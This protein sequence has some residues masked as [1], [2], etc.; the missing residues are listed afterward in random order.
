MRPARISIRRFVAVALAVSAFAVVKAQNEPDPEVRRLYHDPKAREL[1]E[2]AR[3]A[4]TGGPGG[5]ARL[6]SLRLKGQSQ[7]S[8]A[9]GTPF[10]GSVEVRILLPD[11][12]LRIDTGSFGRRLT[13]YAGTAPLNLIESADKHVVAEPKDPASVESARFDLARFMLNMAWVSNEVQVKLYTRETPVDI[14]G[15]EYSPGVDAVSDMRFAARVTFDP[16]SRMPDRVIYRNGSTVMITSVLDRKS[17]SGYKIASHL[18]TRAG[19]RTVD[20]LTFDE[21]VVN[22]S[23]AKTD[24][25]K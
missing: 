6:R 1:F 24:F 11:R 25:A 12:Y 23:L 15:A 3:I 18:V 16:K 5:L 8:G 4:L 2:S 14:P 17:V 9:D 10:S 22:P 21:I 13:G 20:E 7:F 19:D